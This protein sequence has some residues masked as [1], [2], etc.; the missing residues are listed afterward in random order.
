MFRICLLHLF[1]NPDDMFT[2][3]A[4]AVKQR[5]SQRP[6]TE[7][8]D[9]MKNGISWAI[10]FKLPSDRRSPNSENDL[11]QLVVI[12]L[13]LKEARLEQLERSCAAI[14]EDSRLRS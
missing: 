8:A 1:S 11:A 6:I 14:D 2:P 9:R 3:N 4:I 7:I 5:L 13:Q 12:T 10:G